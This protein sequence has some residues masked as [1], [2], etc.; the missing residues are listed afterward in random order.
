MRIF[1]FKLSAAI[2]CLIVCM[3]STTTVSAQK[4]DS[5]SKNIVKLNV[6]ALI[7][8]NFS[9]QYERAVGKR[10][11]VALG[12]RFAPKS[13]LPFKGSF[14]KLIDDEEFSKNIHTFKTGNFALTPEVRFYVGKKGVFH[15]F[16]LAPFVR[17]ATYSAEMPDFEYT[18][19]TETENPNDPDNPIIATE[20]RSILLSGNTKTFTGG[21]MIGS[22]FKLSRQIYLDW[23]IIGASAGSQNG[24]LKG[25]TAQELSGPEQNALREELENFNSKLFDTKITVNKNGADVDVTGPWYTVRAGLAVGFRF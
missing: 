12:V 9:F 7:L 3:L 14:E 22:Q 13:T 10:I 21:L 18:V 20:T 5:L 8:K 15:G 24:N 4:N 23:W 16:Y 17:Y 11:S 25:Y 1:Y 6:P 19:T 2:T